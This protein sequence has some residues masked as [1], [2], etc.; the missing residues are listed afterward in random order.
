MPRAASGIDRVDERMEDAAWRTPSRML[1]T[2]E[3]VGM[4]TAFLAT[5][6][7]RRITGDTMYIGGYHIVGEPAGGRRAAPSP[8]PPRDNHRL[9]SRSRAAFPQ[10]RAWAR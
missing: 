10:A 4:A 2:I 8:R 9:G 7:A 3:D 1:V 6:Q 5:D